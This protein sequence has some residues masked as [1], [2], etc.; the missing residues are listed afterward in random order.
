VQALFADPLYDL[1][2]ASNGSRLKKLREAAGLS[3]REL[4]RQLAQDQSNIHYWESTGKAPRSDVL[5]PMAQVLGVTVEELLGQPKPSRVTGPGGRAR[6]L[7]AAVARLPRRQQQKII[8]VV[9]ALVAQQ[10]NGHKA[11]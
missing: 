8:D 7:F 3:Q 4:A 2:M 9:E 6:Q 5:V 11:A 1:S 10:A